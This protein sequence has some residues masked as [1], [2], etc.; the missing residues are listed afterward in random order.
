MNLFYNKTKCGV[1]VLDELCH[2]YT[3]QRQTRRWPMAVFMNFINVAGV[4]AFVIWQNVNKKFGDPIGQQRKK[5][6]TML[7]MQLTYDQIKRRSLVGLSSS[8]QGSI[9]SIITGQS[10]DG[11]ST[12]EPPQKKVK[13]RCYICPRK[14]ARKIKQ[15]CD[16]C[17]RN[18]CREHSVSSLRCVNCI[19]K[20]I[21]N[22]SDSE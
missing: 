19:K 18:T 16:A 11:E 5:F 10:E 20:P 9:A 13:R 22:A 4:A 8:I 2:N 15:C 7:S 1:D 17:N 12:G 21:I 3:V 14:L 6:L